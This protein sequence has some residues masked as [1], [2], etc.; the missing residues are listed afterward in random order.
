LFNDQ[1]QK[2]IWTVITP[3][4]N[5]YIINKEEKKNMF[6]RHYPAIRANDPQSGESMVTREDNLKIIYRSD[7]SMLVEYEDG[8]RITSFY[9]SLEMNLD[10]NSN[11]AADTNNHRKEKYVKIECPGFATTIFNTK[12]SDCTLVFSNGTLAQCDP[13][14]MGYSIINASGESIDIDKDGLVSLLPR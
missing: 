2:T 9:S 1:K 4:G 13:K 14:K 3:K 6:T 5:E 7:N 11:S 10:P 12:S 8:T